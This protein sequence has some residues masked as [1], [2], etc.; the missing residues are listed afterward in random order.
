MNYVNLNKR[1]D[2]IN[3]DVSERGLHHKTRLR[4]GLFGGKT[5]KNSFN[6]Y[7]N[8]FRFQIIIKV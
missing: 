7:I 6:K 8:L 3:D 5:E 1:V 4:V 2:R